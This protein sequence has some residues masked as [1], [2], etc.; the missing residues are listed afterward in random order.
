MFAQMQTGD[1]E[2]VYGGINTL[3][4]I[5]G[6]EA[7][8]ITAFHFSSGLC[9]HEQGLLSDFFKPVQDKQTDTRIKIVTINGDTAPEPEHKG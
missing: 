7:Y 6:G 5:K 2:M 1:L 3:A 4:W 8:E 9:P